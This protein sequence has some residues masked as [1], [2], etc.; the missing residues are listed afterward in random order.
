MSF[1]VPFDKIKM[2]CNEIQFLEKNVYPELSEAV[3]SVFYYI[4]ILIQY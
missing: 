1:W 3:M 2:S 4:Q